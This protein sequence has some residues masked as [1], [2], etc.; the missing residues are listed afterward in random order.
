MNVCLDRRPLYRMSQRKDNKLIFN[1][2]H[3]IWLFRSNGIRPRSLERRPM[4]PSTFTYKIIFIYKKRSFNK[5]KKRQ[6]WRSQINPVE[7]AK[8]VRG[9]C[10]QFN[11]KGIT[12]L[13][14]F[15]GQTFLLLYSGYI[16]YYK[17]N[18][19]HQYYYFRVYSNKYYCL[20]KKKCRDAYP[21]LVMCVQ[22]LLFIT[23]IYI[24]KGQTILQ[25]YY[26][27]IIYYKPGLKH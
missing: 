14:N 23:S 27:Y 1:H 20:L 24:Y 21:I 9:C 22:C 15:K 7:Q 11:Y 3:D 18:L 17:P 19:K 2:V 26:D 6:E 4:Y 12:P 8:L 16:M 13:Y 5:E 10:V 25:L